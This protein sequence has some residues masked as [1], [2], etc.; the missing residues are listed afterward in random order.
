MTPVVRRV[1]PLAL[2]VL[3]LA[4]LARRAAQPLTIDD[5]YFHLR[6]GHQ[7]LGSWSLRDPGSVTRFATADWRPTQWLSQVAMAWVEDAWGLAGVAWLAGALHVGVVLALYLTARR[8]VAALAAAPLTLVAVAACL[9]ALSMRPQVVSIVLTSV[10]VAWWL[11]ARD[12]G[13]APWALV[14]LTWLWANLH[15]MWP[16]GLAIGAAAAVGLALDDRS[17]RALGR[18]GAVV[19]ASAV[20]AA[21]TPVG[22]GL[23]RAVL[24]V[25]SRGAYFDEW[26]PP[27]PLA[28]A[29][30][31]AG[32][33]VVG[34]LGVLVVRWRSGATAPWLDVALTAAAAVLAA[35]STRTVPIAAALA[36][37]LA[38]R[39]VA[40][41]VEGAGGRIRRGEAALLA[42]AVVVPLV[43]LAVAV[44]HTSADPKPVPTW[45]DAEVAEWP[46]GT[47]LLDT[48]GDGGM[49]MWRYPQLDVLMHGYADL[50]TT[51]ELDRNVAIER[52]D[53]G[54]EARLRDTGIEHAY[55]RTDAPLAAALEAD[56]WAVTHASDGVVLLTAP[57]VRETTDTAP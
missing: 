1:V 11:R 31:C 18:Y 35:Y 38:A 13:R 53:P 12:T 45:L 34:C 23:Y 33:L 39:A 37:P 28:P 6:L 5:T 27:D 47:G 54:W 14:P 50:F 41:Y 21:L 49:L 24:L 15:G 55:L 57:A 9:P 52:V 46:P 22:P 42:A 2:V 30:L 10:T 19:A 51:A 29:T 25:G 36:L 32:A 20:A 56:G 26:G 48:W 40:P 43:A 44:P 7:L 3:A 8:Q 4:A 17:P 16:L